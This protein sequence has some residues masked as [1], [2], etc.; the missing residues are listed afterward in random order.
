MENTRLSQYLSQVTRLWLR[1]TT[2][3]PYFVSSQKFLKDW[4][5]TK[6]LITSKVEIDTI[7]IDFRKAFDSVPLN[8]L[9]TKLWGMGITGTLWKRFKS[10]LHN[11]IQCV[12]VNSYPSSYLPILSGVPQGSILGPLLFLVLLITYHLPIA[13]QSLAYCDDKA[14]PRNFFPMWNLHT[15]AGSFPF[16]NIFHQ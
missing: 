16:I 11:R 1:I 12:S 2:Q 5:T 7:L 6:Q 3:F 13:S 9:L 10:Y 14:L 15:P 8:E 4:S